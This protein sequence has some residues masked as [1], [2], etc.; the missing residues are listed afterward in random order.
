MTHKC[1]FVFV[2]SGSFGWTGAAEVV[3]TSRQYLIPKTDKAITV[4]GKL[5][6]WDMADTPY[7]IS[8]T[9]SS[10][11][12]SIHS[13]DPTNPPQGDND[14]SGKVALAWDSRSLAC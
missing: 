2:L 13:N 3:E 12:T 8:P 9:S 10:P 1:V 4:D 14:L 5:D 7:V 11:M 6:D